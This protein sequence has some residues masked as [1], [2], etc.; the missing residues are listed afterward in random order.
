[1]CCLA[2]VIGGCQQSGDREA[3]CNK[4]G[5]KQR[6]FKNQSL[7]E[8]GLFLWFKICYKHAKKYNWLCHII[9][10]VTQHILTIALATKFLTKF[11]KRALFSS[12]LP[13]SLSS[14]SFS[15]VPSPQGSKT[16]RGMRQPHVEQFCTLEKK[17]HRFR[18]C[19]HSQTIFLSIL[20]KTL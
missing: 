19:L 10:S 14:S 11:N 3:A 16:W 5:G 4:Q 1:M 2:L 15:A 9:G 13:G 17:R 12:S 18:F 20:Y 8:S 6:S 7:G